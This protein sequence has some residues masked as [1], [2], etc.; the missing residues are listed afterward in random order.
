VLWFSA[1][2]D[3]VDAGCYF[4]PFEMFFNIDAHFSHLSFFIIV[5]SSFSQYKLFKALQSSIPLLILSLLLVCLS[6]A[7]DI[8][9]DSVV[10]KVKE[11]MIEG[12]IHDHLFPEGVSSYGLLSG[13]N[14][15]LGE[16]VNYVA[17]LSVSHSPIE[18]WSH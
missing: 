11:G 9:Q 13:A 15:G 5:L 3:V 2:D 1:F 6:E 4:C 18:G 17:R 12:D 7:V 10:M 14:V 8:S 16:K